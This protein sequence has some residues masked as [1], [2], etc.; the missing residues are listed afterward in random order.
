VILVE[1]RCRVRHCRKLLTEVTDPPTTEQGWTHW[2]QLELCPKH[3]EGTGHGNVASW[4]ER[5]RR[6]GKSTDQVRLR[7]WRPWSDLR[8]AV[9]KARRTGRTA[10]FLV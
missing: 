2:W 1:V 10:Q 6:A 9:E 8:P 4:Q 5:Q 7:E 3:G